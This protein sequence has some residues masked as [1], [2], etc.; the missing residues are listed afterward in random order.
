MLSCK[1]VF[2]VLLVTLCLW[3]S[4]VHSQDN[5]NIYQEAMKLGFEADAKVMATVSAALEDLWTVYFPRVLE[6]ISNVSQLCQ[7]ST[8]ALI[9]NNGTTEELVHILDATGKIGAG[10]EAGNFQLKPSF[11]Q[12]FQYNYTSFCM[13]DVRLSFYPPPSPIV[14][15]VGLCVPKYCNSTDITLVL[16]S[17]EVFD[18]GNMRCTDNRDPPY[19]PGAIIMIIVSFLFICLIAA[20]TVLDK[21]LEW[22]ASKPQGIEKLN[23]DSKKKTT[24]EASTGSTE[25]TPLVNPS[26]AVVRSPCGRVNLFEFITAFSLYRTIPTLFATKQAPGVVTCL[27]GLRVMSMF[28]V[29][30]GHTYDFVLEDVDNL[31][32]LTGIMSRF[33]FMAVINANFSVDSFFF[34]S[35]LLVSYLTLRQ[36][37]KTGRFPAVYYYVHRYLR[38]TPTYAFVLFFAWNLGPHFSPG[39]ASAIPIPNAC[40]NYWWTNLLYINNFYPWRLQDECAGWTW[41]LANDMQFYIMAPLVFIPLYYLFPLGLVISSTILVA[42]FITTA[43][44][45]GVYKFE[46]FNPNADPSLIGK[47]NDLLYVKPWNRVA[48]YLVGLVLGYIIY[49][50]IRFRYDRIKNSVFYFMVWVASGTILVSTLYGLYFSFHGHLMSRAEYI[51]YL[52]LSRFAWGVGLALLVFA[53]HNGYGGVINTFLSLKIWTPLSRMTLNAYLFHPIVIFAF[54]GQMQTAVHV[55]DL[56]MGFYAVGFVVVSYGAATIFCVCVELPLGNIEVLLFKLAGVGGRESQR[57]GAV[58]SKEKDDTIMVTQRKA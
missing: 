10:V 46:T 12:C 14:F 42:S 3:L 9:A 49:K 48:P 35:G 39:P 33:S 32:A 38:L 36:M 23:N 44:L 7:N 22:F 57:T 8:A 24:L 37:K 11:D 6:D 40:T 58:T 28:W 43:T 20:G 1:P 27:N 41:Y 5:V 2:L 30:L 53:C 16:N 21:A 26:A 54:Y 4:P 51:I 52:T 47:Y 19:T 45:A 15:K 29:I 55:N 18:V 34:L 31:L 50:Q 13:G 25:K 56:T 17:T